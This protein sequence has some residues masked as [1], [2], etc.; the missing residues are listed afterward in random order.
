MPRSEQGV[1]TRRYTVIPRTLIFIRRWDHV[2]LLKGAA[3]KKI[4]ANKYNGIGGHV[5]RGEDVYSAAARELKEETG[6]AIADVLDFHLCGTIMVDAEENTG[7]S[8]FVFRGEYHENETLIPSAEG[9]LEWAPIDQLGDY[10]LVE[11][12]YTLLPL[13]LALKA[14]MP[15]IIGRT[16]YDADERMVFEV[17]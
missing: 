11:D 10:P 15:P 3:D 14:G 13:V 17:R 5:E 8:I 16:Y 6:L 7:I 4:W 1:D 12:L 9:A 2:L